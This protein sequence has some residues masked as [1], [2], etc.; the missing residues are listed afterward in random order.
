MIFL[1]PEIKTKIK[2]YRFNMEGYELL[3]DYMNIGYKFI[4]GDEAIYNEI[5]RNSDIVLIPDP[6]L[7]EFELANELIE[8]FEDHEEY[9]K[10]ADIQN[11]IKLKK[12]INKLI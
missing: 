5:K 7:S 4:M 1:N 6:E 10:C 8:Y 9:E 12:V 2:I 3:D 11:V